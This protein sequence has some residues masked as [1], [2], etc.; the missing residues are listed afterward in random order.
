MQSTLFKIT[1]VMIIILFLILVSMFIGYFLRDEETKPVVTPRA[2]G[3]QVST[4]APKE[5][6]NNSGEIN[7]DEKLSSGEATLI[8]TPSVAPTI[9]PTAKPT[10]KPDDK[11]NPKPTV[12][13]DETII[14]ENVTEPQSGNTEIDN[15][16][17]EPIAPETVITSTAETSNQEKQ[18]VLNEL[19]EALQGL[20]DVVSK[21]PTVD[22]SKLDASLGSEVQPWWKDYV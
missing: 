14:P 11:T 21:V 8:V 4:K 7:I 13:I 18:Q 17:K 6:K 22:E 9:N 16:E 20:L 5:T 1:T 10:A 2:S 3:E 19:D 12:K 15:K